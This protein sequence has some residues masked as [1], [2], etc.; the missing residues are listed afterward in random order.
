VSADSPDDLPLVRPTSGPA[1]RH[2]RFVDLAPDQ[3][4]NPDH[5]PY[6]KLH[7][8]FGAEIL[9]GEDAPGM[10]GRWAAAFGGRDA[11]LHVEIGSGN[12]FFLSGMA[13]R[14]PEWNWLGIEIRFKRVVLCARKIRAAGVTNARI[15]RYDAWFL[16]DLFAPGDIAGLYV[17]HPDP[18]MK[19]TEQK[20]RLLS[21]FFA[22][23]ASR[24]MAAGAH[25]RI[26]TDHRPAIDAFVAGFG[27]VPLRLTGRSEDIRQDG[28]P[29]GDDDVVTNYQ[30]KFDKRGLPVYAA[31][32]ERLPGPPRE[33]AGSAS[34][35]AAR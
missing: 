24:S 28:A 33:L 16:D 34:D 15:T 6:L 18:W 21:P 5:N 35:G 25:L 8:S 3:Y 4:R 29:W 14:H 19:D 23:W 2:H 30:S 26:K 32:I 20:N 10:R 7:R 9:A 22:A 27:D 13:R 11:P 1:A 17:N 12:G 31:L